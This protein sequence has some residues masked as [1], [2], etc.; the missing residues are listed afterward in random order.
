MTHDGARMVWRATTLMHAE[1]WEIVS[2]MEME[3]RST[4]RGFPENRW[5]PK[6]VRSSVLYG[7]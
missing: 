2:D 3:K 7:T 4:Q 1:T 6:P 5:V